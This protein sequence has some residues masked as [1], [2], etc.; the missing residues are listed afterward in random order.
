[1]AAA[2]AGVKTVL[3]PQA[4]VPDLAEVDQVVKDHVTFIPVRRSDEVLPVAIPSLL[5]HVEKETEVKLRVEPQT[6][7]A[8]TLRQ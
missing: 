4:N 1:M 7:R 8:S 6:H 3:I 2:A 5:E